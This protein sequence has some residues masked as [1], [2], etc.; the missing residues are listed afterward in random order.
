MA[1]LKLVGTELRALIE[2]LEGGG[3]RVPRV[4]SRVLA[5]FAVPQDGV[6]EEN[7]GGKY[8]AWL[9]VIPTCLRQK[10]FQD[11]H[12]PDGRPFWLQ[13]DTS[14]NPRKVL[15]TQAP[16][17]RPLSHKIMRR[18]PMIKIATME[19]SRIVKN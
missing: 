12:V 7:F 5:S 1:A 18:T 9:L 14:T 15:P 4:F 10:I 17:D 19:S 16:K 13:Q 6:Y 2:P 3:N 8:S 11:C